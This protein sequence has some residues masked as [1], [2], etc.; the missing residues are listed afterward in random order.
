MMSMCRILKERQHSGQQPVGSSWF[1]PDGRFTCISDPLVA[2]PARP[3]SYQVLIKG[4]VELG[5]T[6]PA[7]L[8]KKSKIEISVNIY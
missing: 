6:K 3:P 1:Q 2:K 4:S 5:C 8:E 7:L